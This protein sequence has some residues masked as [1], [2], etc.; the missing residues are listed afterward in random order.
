MTQVTSESE[1]FSSR[2]SEGLQFSHK[3]TKQLLR[4]PQISFDGKV[5]TDYNFVQFVRQTK[6]REKYRCQWDSRR[7]QLDIIHRILH[8]LDVTMFQLREQERRVKRL[9][10]HKHF[11]SNGQHKMISIFTS[12]PEFGF[13]LTKIIRID[14][15][16]HCMT[17]LSHLT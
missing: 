8:Y 13:I 7:R 14:L 11:K 4:V 6:T 1:Q 5:R 17:I 9:R 15:T 2:A 16:Q 3:T 12:L 10:T